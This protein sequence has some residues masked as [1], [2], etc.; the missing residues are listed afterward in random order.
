MK[1]PRLWIITAD[2][3]RARFFVK[4]GGH[5]A[6][7]PEAR[8]DEPHPPSRKIGSDKPGRVFESA[9]SSRSATS[10]RVDLHQEAED[11]FAREVAGILTQ[12][13][14]Q[15]DRVLLIAT[16][17]TLG[18]MRPHLLRLESVLDEIPKDLTHLNAKDLGEA[19]ADVV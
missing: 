4:E 2:G 11:N 17:R 7:I 15:Y 18:V 6:E 10:P 3:A 1:S 8:M 5:M 13:A 12:G 19:L 14:H 16:P 9:G